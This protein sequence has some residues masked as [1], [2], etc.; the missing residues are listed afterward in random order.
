M[1]FRDEINTLNQIFKKK[2]LDFYYKSFNSEINMFF[3][4]KVWVVLFCK[5][6]FS[7][8]MKQKVIFMIKKINKISAKILFSSLSAMIP[9]SKTKLQIYLEGFQFNT[10]YLLTGVRE[11]ETYLSQTAQL[12]SQV[13]R[14]KTKIVCESIEISRSRSLSCC[15]NVTS[16]N[17]TPYSEYLITRASPGWTFITFVT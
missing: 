17:K 5:H 14:K 15:T 13:I 4:H 6:S 10:L 8:T 12:R 9:L 11:K 3:K 16:H 1:V 2:L 7:Y